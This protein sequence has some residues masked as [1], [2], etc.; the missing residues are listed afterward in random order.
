VHSETL[1]RLAA[2]GA[3]AASITTALTWIEECGAPMCES[4]GPKTDLGKFLKLL[5]VAA[6]AALLA[7]LASLDCAGIEKL[8][9]GLVKVSGGVIDDLD[10]MFTGT[11][12]LGGVL[13]KAV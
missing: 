13:A 8:L 6:D 12:T 9:A 11:E 7:E 10:A 2:V 1:A 3:L 4:F 5:N